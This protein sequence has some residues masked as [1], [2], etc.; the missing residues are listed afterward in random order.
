MSARM[1]KAAATE[2]YLTR[3]DAN[4]A[5]SGSTTVVDYPSADQTG[6]PAAP[7]KYSFKRLL[8]SLSA[9]EFNRRITEDKVFAAAVD[10]MDNDGN[11]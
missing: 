2:R 9:D 3:T 4:T 11:R 8:D 5:K 1:A 10:K 6:Y 7:T